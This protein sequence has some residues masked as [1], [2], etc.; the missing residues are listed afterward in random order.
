MEAT[1][2]HYEEIERERIEYLRR[3]ENLRIPHDLDYRHPKLNLSNEAIEVLNKHRPANV[4]IYFPTERTCTRFKHIYLYLDIHGFSNIRSI[5]C[6]R[7]QTY[8][9]YK[10]TAKP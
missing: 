2:R 8:L 3:E 6:H 10:K 4:R 1:Y 5:S 7:P 9:F